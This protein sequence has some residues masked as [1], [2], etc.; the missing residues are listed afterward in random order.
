MKTIIQH[1]S[2]LILSVRSLG[3]VT[4]FRYFQ[5]YLRALKDPNFLIEWA[6]ACDQYARKLE[7]FNPDDPIAEAARSWSKTL[8]ECDSQIKHYE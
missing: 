3:L 6:N 1:I 2:M 7:F 5:C 4:G 8:K